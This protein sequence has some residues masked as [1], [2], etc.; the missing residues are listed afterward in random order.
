MTFSISNVH[1]LLFNKVL[2]NSEGLW[3]DFFF[4]LLNTF[5]NLSL[6]YT[7]LIKKHTESTEQHHLNL[8]PGRDQF[9]N[10]TCTHR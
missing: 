1:T 5:L 6:C 2:G 3:F 9:L 10:T 7:L 8:I 4:V